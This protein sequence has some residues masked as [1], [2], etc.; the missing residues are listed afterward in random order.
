MKTRFVSLAFSMFVVAL[1]VVLSTADAEPKSDKWCSVVYIYREPRSGK[2]FLK[3]NEYLLRQTTAKPRR[4]RFRSLWSYNPTAKQWAKIKRK[5]GL[6]VVIKPVKRDIYSYKSDPT[7]LVLPDE[8][9]LFWLEWSEDG[10]KVNGIA[11]SGP[12]LCN[13]ITIS[14]PPKGM[15]AACVP[16]D[17]HATAMFVPDPKIH[18]RE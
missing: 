1:I 2:C 11:V 12:V 10:R 16:F 14:K 7:L 17:D 5:A 8:V 9:G 13:D 15:I 18:C 6:P 3:A 4:F